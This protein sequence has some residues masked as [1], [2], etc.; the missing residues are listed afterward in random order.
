MKIQRPRIASRGQTPGV[1]YQT[2]LPEHLPQTDAIF[3]SLEQGRTPTFLEIMFAI[4]EIGDFYTQL[5]HNLPPSAPCSKIPSQKR[6]R[7]CC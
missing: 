2:T 4:S 1:G 7:N 3:R 5:R 6:C